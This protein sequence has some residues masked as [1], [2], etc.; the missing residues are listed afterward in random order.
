MAYIGVTGFTSVEQ[1]KRV[2]N[3]FPKDPEA[4]FEVEGGGQVGQV[5]DRPHLMVG[6]LAS[7]KSLHG[8]LHRHPKKMPPVDQIS[9]IFSLGIWG[10]LN[11]IH[12]SADPDQLTELAGQLALM[13]LY[14]GDELH[15]FQ[16]NIRWPNREELR[17]F[18]D[19]AS[20]LVPDLYRLV[21]QV[22]AAALEISNHDPLTVAR[23]IK[24]YLDDEVITDVLIDPSG[25]RGLPF[26]VDKARRY[27]T[28]IRDKCGQSVGLGMAG[29][30]GPDSLD[31]VAPL[32]E[33]F[34]GQLSID[35]QGR[36][37]NDADD[38]DPEKCERYVR[39]ALELYSFRDINLI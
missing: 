36:L 12:Y 3:A 10:G 7:W 16:L 39:Q 34:Q 25:G 28:A 13:T 37:R 30:L 35:A 8:V 26:D 31:L 1:V 11:L 4:D 17:R 27:L 5:P 18:W 32:I 24:Q 38:L 29:G 6:V 23:H 20:C 14:G 22:G 15:G 9:D 33:E 19:A 2:K 21:L